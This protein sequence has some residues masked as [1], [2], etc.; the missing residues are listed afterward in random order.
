M[1]K[2]FT[3][4]FF[5][6]L[7]PGLSQAGPE[8]LAIQSIR[9][10]PYEDAIKG[11][12]AVCNARINRIVI[13][14]LGGTDVV[15]KINEI[16]PDIVL[17][18]G[19]DALSMVKR[20]KSIPIVYV[21]VLNPQSILFGEK[22]ITGVSMNIP[23]GKQLM[24]LLDALPYAKN[25]GLLYDPNRTGYLVRNA[26]DTARKIGIKLIAKEVHSSRDAPSLIMDMKEK[27]DAFWM[28]PDITLIT[29]ETVKFLLLFS[30]ENNIPLLAFS[31]KYVEAGAFMSTGIDAFDMGIQAGELANKILSGRGAKD[32]QQVCAR[33]VVVSTNLMIARKLGINLNIAMSVGNSSR[34]KIIREARMLN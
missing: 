9:V 23:P 11:F 5:L 1:K 8:I 28:L 16:R 14:E 29:P 26:R 10:K 6:I 19:R 27:I 13:S 20:I 21:M 31:E 33:K 4:L 7:F 15:R 18:I 22:N 30:F 3:I 32:V 17:A 2:P 24:M 12:Q 25:I 34:E